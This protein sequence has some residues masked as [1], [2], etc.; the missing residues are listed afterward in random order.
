[1]SMEKCL[2]R[3]GHAFSILLGLIESAIQQGR[4]VLC[5][6]SRMLWCFPLTRNT[7]EC[8]YKI[9]SGHARARL[10]SWKKNIERSAKQQGLMA[11]AHGAFQAMDLRHGGIVGE[12]GRELDLMRRR[13][14]KANTFG[15]DDQKN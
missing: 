10:E 3:T 1:M 2:E 6:K 13:G 11:A 15:S 12:F 4:I 9:G 8:L 7:M 14:P 5:T